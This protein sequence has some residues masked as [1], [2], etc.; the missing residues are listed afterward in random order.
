MRR[1]YHMPFDPACRGVRLALAEKG[2]PAQ[3][4]PAAPWATEGDLAQVN[5]AGTIPVLVDEPPTGGEFNICGAHVIF[6][7]LEDAYGTTKLMPATASGRAEL[8]RLVDWLTGKFENEVIALTVRE[9]IDRRI[10]RRGPPD[11]ERL[12]RGAKALSWHLDY[13]EWLLETRTWFAGES[14]TY[15]DLAAAGALS[16][17]DYIGAAP[18]DDFKALREWYARMKSRPSMRPL[19]ADR[20][21]GVP[22]P[23]H[24]EDPDF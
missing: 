3:F 5:P 24:F 20:F 16:A 11:F 6:D 9:K 18:W 2:L 4:V 8:R 19:L 1:L 23:A 14:M 15:A 21:D 12:S 17:L 10:S 7:Y 13:F 22:P